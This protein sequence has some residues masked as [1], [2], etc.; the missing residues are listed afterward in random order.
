MKVLVTGGT[1]LVGKSLQKIQPKWFYLSTRDCNLKDLN[2]VLGV[3]SY[4]KPDV[5]IHLA[6]DVGGLFKNLNNNFEMYMNNISINNNVVEACKK[7]KVKKFIPI[8]STCIYPD[9]IEYPITEDKLHDGAPHPSNIGYSYAKRM[10]DVAST[11]LENTTNTKVIKLIPTNLYGPNDNFNLDKGH[12]LPSLI[13]ACY[14]SK[15]NNEIF[16]VLGTGK[17]LRQ[18]LYVDDLAKIIEYFVFN[19]VEKNS[20]IIAPDEEYS[21]KELAIEISNNFENKNKIVFDTSFS[22]GQ[23]KKTV[24]NSRL[25]EI[26]NFKFTTLKEGIEKTVEWFKNNQDTFRH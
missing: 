9:K 10:L 22:D 21:I 25:K 2:L 4:Y 24:S 26:Y 17:P 19:D 14:L 15:K 7:L 18:F 5:V 6:A 3:F 16:R 11:L 12:V 8:L 23:L 13:H 20:F 1:G